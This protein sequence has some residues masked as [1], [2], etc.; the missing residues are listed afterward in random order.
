MDRLL[1]YYVHEGRCRS[2][3]EEA[4]TV[5]EETKKVGWEAHHELM[6][7]HPRCDAIGEIANENRN[8]SLEVSEGR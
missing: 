5:A 3:A 1:I 6:R 4:F 7:L 2:H 8:V